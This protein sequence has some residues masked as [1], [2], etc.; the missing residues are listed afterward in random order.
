[1]EE[2]G[3]ECTVFGDGAPDL[4]GALLVWGNPDDRREQAVLVRLLRAGL[5]VPLVQPGLA[6]HSGQM[7]GVAVD[8][9]EA[10]RLALGVGR[11]DGEIRLEGERSTLRDLER[12]PRCGLGLQLENLEAVRSCLLV[13][14]CG[15][16]SDLQ[17]VGEEPGSGVDVA[18]S[19]GLAASGA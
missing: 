3:I 9:D 16:P 10:V 6:Q 2:P 7:L 4:V 19:A 18:P 1:M 11:D 12:P 14:G 17:R 5:P 13:E 15:A 8:L